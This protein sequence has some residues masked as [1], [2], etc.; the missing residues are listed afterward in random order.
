M[1]EKNKLFVFERKEVALIF[2]FMVLITVTSFTLGVRFGKQV[3]LKQDGY[4]SGDQKTINLKSAEEEYV[5][6][7]IDTNDQGDAQFD[8]SMQNEESENLKSETE[9]NLEK[10]LEKLAV[11]KNIRA[12]VKEAMQANEMAKQTE[13]QEQGSDLYAPRTQV[14]GKFTIQ[15]ASFN[16]EKEAQDFADGFIAGGHDA[17]IRE[18]ELNQSKWYRVSV[19]IFETLDQAKEYLK[20]NDSFFHGKEYLI[21]QFK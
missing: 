12:E 4:T 6:K 2:I 13:A 20:T 15:L 7:V 11:S 10:E 18:V 14:S 17:I 19:G 1:E 5:D 16:N 9:K 21:K 3:S 8:S